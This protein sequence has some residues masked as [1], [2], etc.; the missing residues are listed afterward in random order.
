MEYW[1]GVN[2]WNFAPT[3]KTNLKNAFDSFV[4]KW[5]LYRMSLEPDF[6]TIVKC[7]KYRKQNCPIISDSPVISFSETEDY[8]MTDVHNEKQR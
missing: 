2:L 6:K 5:I 8:V 3:R 4:E 7:L 1:V